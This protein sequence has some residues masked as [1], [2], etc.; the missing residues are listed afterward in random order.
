MEYKQTHTHIYADHFFLKKEYWNKTCFDHILIIAID[1][2]DFDELVQPNTTSYGSKFQSLIMHYVFFFKFFTPNP[3]WWFLNMFKLF[4]ERCF[5]E[6][7]L[8]NIV[9]EHAQLSYEAAQ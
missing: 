1:P 9:I 5:I 3:T 4:G 8:R 7:I 2:H 6:H